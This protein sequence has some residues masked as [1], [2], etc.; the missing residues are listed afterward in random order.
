MIARPST[1]ERYPRSPCRDA[2]RRNKAESLDAKRHSIGPG[3]PPSNGASQGDQG[4]RGRGP[5]RGTAQRKHQL[6][7]CYR[8]PGPL[9]TRMC[10]IPG[11]SQ[12][13]HAP[14]STLPVGALPRPTCCHIRWAGTQMCL[15]GAQHRSITSKGENRQNTLWPNPMTRLKPRGLLSGTT[16]RDTLIGVLRS[17]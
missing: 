6:S 16:I 3:R 15:A 9:S 17:P 8:R 5:E 12:K 4:K 10:L 11:T 7:R 13:R 1:N 14:R 2:T